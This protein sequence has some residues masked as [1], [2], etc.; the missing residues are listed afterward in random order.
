MLLTPYI[1]SC[2]APSDNL[3]LAEATENSFKSDACMYT[4]S[5]TCSIH[6]HIVH[7]HVHVVYTLYL[8]SYKQQLPLAA[9]VEDEGF[10][11]GIYI[12]LHMSLYMACN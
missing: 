2:S 8:N 7:V 4:S 9:C 5:C 3:L 11:T 12:L 6:T 10:S 1:L